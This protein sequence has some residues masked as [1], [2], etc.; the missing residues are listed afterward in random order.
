MVEDAIQDLFLYLLSKKENLTVP[1]YV[2]YYLLKAFKR[3][4]DEG[5]YVLNSEYDFL[6]R[7]SL[8]FDDGTNQKTKEKKL[9]LIEQLME[10]MASKRKEVLFLKFHSSLS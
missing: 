10:Q 5:S 8:E 7:Y 2:R 3:I 1:R 9:E 6:F 4:K